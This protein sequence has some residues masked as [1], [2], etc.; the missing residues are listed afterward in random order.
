[1]PTQYFSFSACDEVVDHV[2]KYDDWADG[3]NG[4]HLSVANKD[5]CA[6]LC[7][8]T[9]QGY[10]YSTLYKKCL[11]TDKA[12]VKADLSDTS[13]SETDLGWIHY[14]CETSTTTAPTT[15][16]ATTSKPLKLN[17]ARPEMS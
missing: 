13:G 11:I 14:N 3:V 10:S 12:L 7:T 4:R 8:G 9:C 1:M 2:V 16:T 17:I 5:A 6:A 15:T